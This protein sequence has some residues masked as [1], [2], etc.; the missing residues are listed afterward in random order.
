ME[1]SEQCSRWGEWGTL[2]KIPPKRTHFYQLW[3]NEQGFHRWIKISGVDVEGWSLNKRKGS[4]SSQ[5]R[6]GS[7]KDRY[8]YR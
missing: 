6:K 8:K 5:A 4:S 2:E 1:E 3:K 7:R